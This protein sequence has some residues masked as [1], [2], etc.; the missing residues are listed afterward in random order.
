MAETAARQ[1]RVKEPE[2][3]TT[4][5]ITPAKRPARHLAP[6]SAFER[7]IDSLF[8]EFRHRFSWPRLFGRERRFAPLEER[9]PIPSI[10][11]YEKNDEVI[12]KAELPGMSK[13]DIE[14]TLTDSTLTVKGEKRKEEEV[15]EGDYYRSE[16]SFGSIVR[17][18]DL[19]SE[20][21]A[22]Q[23]KATF[24][25]GVLEVR[26]PKTEEAKQKPVKIQIQ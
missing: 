26:L 12:V 20:V 22:D 19:P 21:K 13:N 5:E 3:K 24:G 6:V 9:I 1:E 16:R 11:V 18:V 14:V 8:D 7:E 4:H 10:D 23:A 2:K 25:D 15:K 17:T